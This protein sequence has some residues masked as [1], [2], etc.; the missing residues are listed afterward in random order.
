MPTGGA[1]GMLLT[2]TAE[3][4]RDFPGVARRTF[5]LRPAGVDVFLAGVAKALL[6]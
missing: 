4:E 1:F 6:S 5:K 2:S 3:H